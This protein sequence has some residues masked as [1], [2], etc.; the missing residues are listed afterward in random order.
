[1]IPAAFVCVD[2][3][4]LTSNG[5]LDRNALPAPGND[6]FDVQAYEA[7]KGEIEVVLSSIWADLLNVERVGRHDSFFALG[8]HSLLA[9]RMIGRIRSTLGFEVSLRDLFEVPTIAE[10][11]PQ[12]LSTRATQESSY[13]VLLPIKPKGSRAPLFCIHPGMGLSWCF[14]AFLAGLDP[15]QPLYGLQARGFIGDEPVAS[16]LDE[17]ALDY[18]D[19][20]R[21]IQ[22]HGPYHLIGFSFGGMV[23]HTMASH[24][25]EQGERVA[26]LA[27]MDTVADYHTRDLKAAYQDE[28]KKVDEDLIAVLV[29]DADQYSGDLIKPLLKKVRM[30]HDNNYRI[31]SAKAPRV[32]HGD[33]LIFRATKL[34]RGQD[35]LW[36]PDD[37]RPYVLGGIDV[38]D[39]DCLHMDMLLPEPLAIVTQVL[40]ERL[41]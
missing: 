30:I 1:M 13:D 2:K 14:A 29:G 21:H 37:W 41:K 31:I 36:S 19:Q 39:I 22:P 11:A 38:C 6:A 15:D 16:T 40:N 34:D 35:E 33:M 24:L 7:P 12:L 10:L 28:K 4:P 25:E 26:L 32:I 8:G 17:M 27:L 18:I 5:K 23:A 3:F 9:V 20:I